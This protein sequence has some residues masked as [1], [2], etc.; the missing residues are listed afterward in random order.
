MKELIAKLEKLKGQLPNFGELL[1]KAIF[2]KEEDRQFI[3]SFLVQYLKKNSDIAAL[4]VFESP[5]VTNKAEKNWR[6]LIRIR[7]KCGQCNQ[8]AEELQNLFIAEGP[9]RLKGKPICEIC[10]ESNTEDSRDYASEM[11]A[12]EEED[13]HNELEA[14][15]SG[16]SIKNGKEQEKK[17]QQESSN[18]S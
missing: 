9:L 2:R 1:S 6:F 5:G 17:N 14:S 13:A 11:D 12:T 4:D 8:I 16:F 18:N 7:F 3:L 15:R 10:N